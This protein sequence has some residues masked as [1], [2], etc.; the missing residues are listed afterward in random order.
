[1]RNPFC[2]GFTTATTYSAFL[3]IVT[4]PGDLT[5]LIGLPTESTAFIKTALKSWLKQTKLLGQTKSSCFILTNAG[6]AF[7]SA[8]FITACNDLGI[9]LEADAPEHQEM[10]GICEAKWHKV[11]NTA[12]ILL[13]TP[14]LGGAFFHHVHA[15]AI[16]TVNSCPTKNVTDQ[17]GNPTTPYQ[18]TYGRKPILANFRI[19]GC[20]VYF[21]HYEAT[22][23]NKLITYK[24]QFQCSSCGIFIGFP[25]NSAN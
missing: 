6:S 21:K 9:K 23:H 8:K 20:P 17:D 2:Y 13:N 10:N 4:T 5:G 15:Y 25:E 18:Y 11:H 22:I 12:I 1:M 7:T 16:H 14:Q 3:F 19:L 24:Q